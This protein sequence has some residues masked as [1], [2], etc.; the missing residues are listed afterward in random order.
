LRSFLADLARGR[1]LVL[2]GS[3]GG[4]D[5]LAKGTFDDNV[6]DL[7]GLDDEAAS[8]LAD[9]ILERNHATKYRKDEQEQE[10]LQKLIRVLN[11][12]PWLWR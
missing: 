7:G 8:T 5:W 2:L 6:Y 10:N 11:G 3:R 12:F 9:R 4:E 1:T